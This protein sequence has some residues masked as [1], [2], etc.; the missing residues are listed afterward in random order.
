VSLLSALVLFDKLRA[1]GRFHN[2]GLRVHVLVE[3]ASSKSPA[4]A[5]GASPE[6]RR[7]LALV[8]R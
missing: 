6:W 8:L 5:E 3:P 4:A 2:V 7:M 1:E